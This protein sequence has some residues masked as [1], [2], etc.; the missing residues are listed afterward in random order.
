MWPTKTTKKINIT[1]ILWKTYQVTSWSTRGSITPSFSALLHWQTPGVYKTPPLC[2]PSSH[3]CP[4]PYWYKDKLCT[5]LAAVLSYE[6][7][8]F[9]YLTWHYLLGWFLSK[10]PRNLP[11]EEQMATPCQGPLP[12]QPASASLLTYYTLLFA[13]LNTSPHLEKFMNYK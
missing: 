10:I 11:S 1:L 2:K 13:S 6:I 12:D 3:T 5:F 4:R 7:R 9:E 8:C